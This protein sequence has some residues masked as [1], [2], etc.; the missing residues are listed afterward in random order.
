MGIVKNSSLYLISNLILKGAGFLLLPL[1]THLISPSEFGIIFLI[2]LTASLIAA[3]VSLSVR[4]TIGRFYFDCKTDSEVSLLYSTILWFILLFSVV[5]YLALFLFSDKIAV[6]IGVPNYPY[7]YM[8]LIISFLSIYYP[9]V[10][11]LL[12]AKQE[13]KQIS[14]ITIISGVMV[15]VLNIILV[16]NLEDK[17][18]AYLLS[19]IISGIINLIIFIIYS[20]KHIIFK[21][22]SHNFRTYLKYSLHQLPSDLSGWIITFSDRLFINKMLGNFSTGIY[23]LGYKIGSVNQIVYQSINK[24]YVPFVFSKYKDF[25]KDAKKVVEKLA[26]NVFVLYSFIGVLI[27]IFHKEIL[28]TIDSRYHNASIIIFLILITYLFD[29]YRLVFNNPLAY[30]TKY[31]KYKSI[32]LISSAFLNI[33]LNLVLIPKF[34]IAGAAIAT[35]I[36]VILKFIA[37]FVIA[38]KAMKINYNYRKMF[39]VFFISLFVISSS[40]IDLSIIAFF[41]KVVLIGIYGI[42]LLKILNINKQDLLNLILTRKV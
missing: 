38:N 20:K 9:L 21:F 12:Y 3:V 28:L 29:G 15:L 14:I 4:A 39:F 30:N 35:L 40:F 6:S 42:L 25:T 19:G 7:F 17:I 1:Y 41:T 22:D 18:F 13:G 8:G 26:L 27:T 24:A 36:T 2:Q 33:V 31:T 37:I 34:N 10:T 23:S 5:I 32:V 11:G 16:V